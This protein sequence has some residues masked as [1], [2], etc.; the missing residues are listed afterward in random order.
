MGGQHWDILV[1][2]GKEARRDGY[3]RLWKD[4]KLPENEL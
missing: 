1:A 3:E 4:L 2:A